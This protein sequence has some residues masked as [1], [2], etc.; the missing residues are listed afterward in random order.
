MRMVIF[1][2]YVCGKQW[3]RHHKHILSEISGKYESHAKP[4][5]SMNEPSLANNIV[6]TCEN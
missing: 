3:G 2:V 5:Y 4:I 1:G 6:V